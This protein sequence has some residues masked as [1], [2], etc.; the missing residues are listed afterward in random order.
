M[1]SYSKILTAIRPKTSFG[2]E[3]IHV[4]KTAELEAA[5]VGY[6]VSPQGENLIGNAEGEWREN[7]LVIGYED[8][9]GD[10]IFIDT[11]AAGFPVYTAIHGEG[12]WK[13]NSI[14]DSL[15]GFESALAVVGRVSENRDTP[16][17]LEDNP[18]PEEQKNQTL[19]EIRRSNPQAD[20]EFWEIL[21][22]TND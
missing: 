1:E 9:C 15:A 10:P 5:Q 4:F 20:L 22:T 7:W 13:P 12:S 3:T 19:A 2:Y 18:L 8:L 16:R 21:L 11:K 14:A 6:S 17:A